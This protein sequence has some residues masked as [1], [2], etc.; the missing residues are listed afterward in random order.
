MGGGGGGSKIISAFQLHE[1]KMG[2]VIMGKV[3]CCPL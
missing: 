3:Y 1:R 2:K